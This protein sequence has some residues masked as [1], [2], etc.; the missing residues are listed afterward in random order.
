MGDGKEQFGARI[1]CPVS[2]D[3]LIYLSRF[4]SVIRAPSGSVLP[5]GLSTISK[6]RTMFIVINRI[7]ASAEFTTGVKST[8]TPKLQRRDAI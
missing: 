6:G 1:A 3:K 2:R 8:G 5:L 7:P 4:I